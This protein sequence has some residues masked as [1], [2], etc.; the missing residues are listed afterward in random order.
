MDTRILIFGD[1]ITWGAVDEDGGGWAQR[2]KQ[3]VDKKTLTPDYASSVYV[4]GVSG[5]T[6]DELLKRFNSEVQARLDE[7]ADLMLIFA[8]GTND[9]Y[10]D[11]KSQR[12]QVSRETF[13]QNLRELIHHAKK[14]TQNILFLGLA[15]VDQR[16]NPMPWKPTHAYLIEEIAKYNDTLRETAEKEGVTFLDLFS[17]M[18]EENYR[19]LLFDGLYPNTEGHKYIYNFVIESLIDKSVV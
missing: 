11:V 5:D 14:Y 16:V 6:T 18:S 4:L 3:Y 10:I 1:S 9:S 12:N 17:K 19:K 8:I 15:P 13:R 2:I 7:E